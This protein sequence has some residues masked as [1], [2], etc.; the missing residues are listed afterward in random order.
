MP[1]RD[2][3]ADLLAEGLAV[4][5]EAHWGAGFLAGRY[6]PGRPSWTWPEVTRRYLDG[7]ERLLD[8]GTGDGSQLRALEPWPACT[9]A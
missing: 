4:D 3:F 2:D 7:A 8:M 6:L 1:A 5:V 9:I